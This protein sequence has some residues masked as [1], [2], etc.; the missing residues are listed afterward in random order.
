MTEEEIRTKRNELIADSDKHILSDYPHT[1]NERA[2]WRRYRQ[3]LRDITAQS[4]FPDRVT[5]PDVPEN[6]PEI[7]EETGAVMTEE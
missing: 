3:Q 1:E 7:S 6:D 2:R 5:F 4:G